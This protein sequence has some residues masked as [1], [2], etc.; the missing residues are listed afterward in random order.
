MGKR[1]DEARLTGSAA[2][3]NESPDQ[4]APMSEPDQRG[5]SHR[6]KRQHARVRKRRAIQPF[7]PPRHDGMS[8]GIPDSAARPVGLFSCGLRPSTCVA[9]NARK[10][11]IANV[12]RTFRLVL[13]CFGCTLLL[14]ALPAQ[15]AQNAAPRGPVPAPIVSAHKLF[16]ANAGMD[17]FSLQAFEELGL[18]GTD[19]YDSLYAAAGKL[20]G[21]QVVASPADADL[22]L[23]IR[24][25]A[26]MTNVGDHQ[27][28]G[29][30]RIL[31]NTTWQFQT[32][33]NILDAKTHFL[34]WSITEPVRPANLK[35]T[36]RKNIGDANATLAGDLKALLGSATPPTP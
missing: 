9:R 26:P 20:D 23:E 3:R 31:A 29:F 34:L 35:G 14:P 10:V 28:W 25:T 1:F 18:N 6:D 5:S 4:R 22:V 2:Y 13:L 36:W 27:T 24:F 21:Y 11:E 8:T 17:A 16:I 30:Q 7:E 33:V 32:Q 15:T 19:A 12:T